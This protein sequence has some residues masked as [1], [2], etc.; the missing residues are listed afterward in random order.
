MLPRPKILPLS[1]ILIY[2]VALMILL[3]LVLSTPFVAFHSGNTVGQGTG[4][5]ADE[6]AVPALGAGGRSGDTDGDAGELA[7][8]LLRLGLPLLDVYSDNP[9]YNHNG[10]ALLLGW[11]AGE[12][13][14]GALDFLRLQMPVLAL[15]EPDPVTVAS[16]RDGSSRLPLPLV[17]P[18]DG[19]AVIPPSR[20]V[21]P[22][23]SPRVIVYQ[24]HS[25]ESFAPV[26]AQVGLDESRPYTKDTEINIV[27]VGEELARSL[28]ELGIPVVHLRTLFDGNGLTGSYMESEKGVK[29]A[30]RRYPTARVLIDVHRDATPREGTVTV[31]GGKPVARVLMVVGMGN[32]YLPNPH[33]RANQAFAR[34]IARVLDTLFPSDPL[35]LSSAGS[36]GQRYPALVRQLADSD[37]DP[38]TFGRDGRFNQHLSEQ[39]ILVEI[40]GPENTLIEELRTARM[41]ARAVASELRR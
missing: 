12:W 15:A 31:I 21:S 7:R 20:P 4:Y 29:E 23:S 38:W 14:G 41:V 2:L 34:Q 3:T 25:Q 18:D 9:L 28:Q 37:G 17:S 33:W 1:A 22:D 39:A 11:M 26:L 16:E 8:I 10:A 6:P 19:L 40:G 13:Q 27:R 32:R 36:S 5:G 35:P 24:T 30:M